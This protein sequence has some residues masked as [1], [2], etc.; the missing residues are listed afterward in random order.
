M[1]L[2]DR[3]FFLLTSSLVSIS[4]LS[5]AAA[6]RR[7]FRV[8]LP[9]YPISSAQALIVLKRLAYFLSNSPAFTNLQQHML[10]M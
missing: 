8:T 10:V 5:R 1:H 3:T 4:S 7:L 2:K 9:T 6:M